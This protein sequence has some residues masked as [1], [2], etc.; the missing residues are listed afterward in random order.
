MTID[1][2]KQHPLFAQLTAKQQAFTEHFIQTQDLIISSRAAYN[3]K[4]EHSAEMLARKNL[5][6]PI[7]KQLVAM[8]LKYEPTGGLL[9]KGEMMLA[10]SEKIRTA[11][12]VSDFTKL[13]MIFS[14]LKGWTGRKKFG[15]PDIKDAVLEMEQTI[16]R[17]NQEQR[18]KGNKR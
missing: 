17:R 16:K 18:L 13:V 15:E 1:K 2:I 14:E 11:K 5:K 8:A 4:D 9:T 7:V 3:C 10:M 12:R 6:H